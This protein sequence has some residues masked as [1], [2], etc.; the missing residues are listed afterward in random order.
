MNAVAVAP[1]A[2]GPDAGSIVMRFVRGSD[3]K[4]TDIQ[5]VRGVRGLQKAAEK[6]LHGAGV[7]PPLPSGFPASTTIAMNLIISP[8]GATGAAAYKFEQHRA[9][10]LASAAQNNASLEQDTLSQLAMRAPAK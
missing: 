3:G 8:S 1:D 9:L 4:A 10:A 5:F 6:T 7:L 2:N